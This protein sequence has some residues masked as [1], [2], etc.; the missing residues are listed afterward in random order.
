MGFRSCAPQ[1]EEACASGNLQCGGVIEHEDGDE[2]RDGA[3][4]FGEG[5]PCLRA[6]KFRERR[7]GE[8]AHNACSQDKR[9][10]AYDA[11]CWQKRAHA[12]VEEKLA[13]QKREGEQRESGKRF[14]RFSFD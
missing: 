10:R 14:E 5:Y 6:R 2:A 7:E 9:L 4:G 8:K 13:S 1:K 11:F 3:C 12:P